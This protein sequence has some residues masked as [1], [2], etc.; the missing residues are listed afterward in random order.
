MP[1]PLT[2]K[3]MVLGRIEDDPTVRIVPI[4]ARV[5]KL[6]RL[7]MNRDAVMFLVQAGVNSLFQMPSGS[8]ACWAVTLPIHVVRAGEEPQLAD[9]QGTD[10]SRI[11]KPGLAMVPNI[12]GKT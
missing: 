3:L 1:D 8:D 6:L 2:L 12:E 5:P 10:G 9:Q 11:I 4:G 7:W